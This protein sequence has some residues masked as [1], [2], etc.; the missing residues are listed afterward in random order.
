LEEALRQVLGE[1]TPPQEIEKLAKPARELI[2]AA[3]QLKS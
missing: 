2:Q 3:V 1:K